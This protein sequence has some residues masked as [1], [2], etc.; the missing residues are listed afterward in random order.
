MTRLKVRAA[1][2]S[3]IGL[4]AAY[5][6][7]PGLQAQTASA[8]CGV[9]T[10]STADQKH[11]VLPCTAPTPQSADGK[12]TCGIATWSQAEQKYTVVPCMSATEANGKDACSLL[13]WSQADQR[14]VMSPCGST[15]KSGLTAPIHFGE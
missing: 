7:M 13:T 10:W 12:A 14:Y 4:S 6:A 9:L 11:S 2:I 3:L 5:A 1:C 8:N 15:D